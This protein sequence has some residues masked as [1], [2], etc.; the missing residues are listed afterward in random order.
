MTTLL[1]PTAVDEL[2][3]EAE[4]RATSLRYYCF[5]R[6][7]IA[8]LL[9]V[10][11]AV[12]KL[13]SELPALFAA[14][15][16]AYWLA[17]I[18][19]L[20]ILPRSERAQ[21][22]WLAVQVIVDV[23]ALTVLTH[24]DGGYRSGIP[25]LLMT[26]L[27]AAGLVAQGRMVLGF[28]ALATIAVLIEHSLRVGAGMS[29]VGEY[30]RIGLIGMGYFAVALVSRM[31]GRRAAQNA[32]LAQQRGQDL[33][34]QMGIN[35]RIIEDM[36]DGVIVLDH[37]GQVRLAN[38]QAV[39][40]LGP[41]LRPGGHI[42]EASRE[43]MR[44]AL[45]HDVDDPV[46]RAEHGGTTLRLRQVQVDDSGTLVVYLEDLGRLQAQAQQIKLAA[47]GRL[48]ANIAHEIRNPLAAITHASELMLEE[49][50]AE[51]QSRLVRIV[52]DNGARIERM[53]R[54]VM[55]L[56]RRDRVTAEA[57]DI[58]AFVGT[59]LDELAMPSP[60]IVAMVT[61]ECEASLRLRFDR[62]HLHQILTNLV[63]NACRYGSGQ[64]GSVRVVGRAQDDAITLTVSDDGPGIA[65][66]DRAKVFE[67]FFTSDPKGTGLGLYIAR[68]LAEANG[69]RLALLEPGET[70]SPGAV[71]RLTAR[72]A[73]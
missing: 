72:R 21:R 51:M 32:V 60:Q 73:D 67:P 6:I 68:E 10:F 24:A 16:G 42:G 59:F 3:G 41:A 2:S 58:A 44:R 66:A 37:V 70:A 47:L 31:L 38:P 1:P 23:V 36:Q 17:S 46:F 20:M 63:S 29:E 57:L 8:S 52:R 12:L 55:D 39:A 27:A 33:A 69:A 7:V 25:Y 48:T 40:Q 28:A 49:K 45:L 11:G 26:S 50:R 43:L 30:S 18:A 14:T 53:V 65:E 35:A 5:Y 64:P 34:R 15:I 56:G 9:A 61:A 13:G 19:A 71:F 22:R 54:D 62:V 4:A